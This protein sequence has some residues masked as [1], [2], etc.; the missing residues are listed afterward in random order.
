MGIT[1]DAMTPIGETPLFRELAARRSPF[2]D[3]FMIDY[4]P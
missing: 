1:H 3:G 2:A 4:P